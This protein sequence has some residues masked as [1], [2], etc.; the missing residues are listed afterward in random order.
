M[1]LKE[2]QL[3]FLRAYA[4]TL[5]ILLSCQKSGVGRTT[6]WEWRKEN[7]E[8]LEAF[9]EAEDDFRDYVD[10]TVQARVPKSDLILI[11]WA[12]ANAPNKYGDKATVKHELG[13]TFSDFIRG[14]V[15][16]ARQAGGNEVLPT[17]S[18]EVLSVGL[19]DR[20]LEQANPDSQFSQGQ[21]QDGGPQL[22]DGG[23][24]GNSV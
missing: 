24:D 10:A 11:F 13:N 23:Q 8:F 15:Q 16:L 6:V 20:T 9:K 7:P 5:N 17:Q 3:A 4:K 1:A 12:K 22:H 2:E 14:T 21:S 19:G 18:S